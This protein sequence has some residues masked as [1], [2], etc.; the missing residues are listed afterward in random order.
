MTL[1]SPVAPSQSWSPGWILPVILLKAAMV[2]GVGP[3]WWPDSSDY[4]S[5]AKVILRDGL[6]L[7]TVEFYENYN[8]GFAFR[9]LGYPLLLAATKLVFE[10]S[11]GHAVIVFQS[12]LSVALFV[13][14]L[15]LTPFCLKFRGAS[16]LITVLYMLSPMTIFNV[17]ILSDSISAVLVAGSM[18]VILGAIVGAWQFSPR[19]AL[20]VGVAWALSV[21]IRDANLYF[22]FLP[23]VGVLLWAFVRH[24]TVSRGTAM[25][26]FVLAPVLLASEGYKSWNEH[27]TGDRFLSTT[28]SA[29][30]LR[31]VFDLKRHG[32]GDP[33]TGDDAVD[34][35]VRRVKP[36]LS[37][38][39]NLVVL[40][41]LQRYEGVSASNL[42][43]IVRD[44]YI[45]TV[46]MHA[47]PV[48][49][50]GGDSKISNR[51][52]RVYF[53]RP[54]LSIRLLVPVFDRVRSAL[55]PIH[56]GLAAADGRSKQY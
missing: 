44:K 22:V 4:T 41:D 32:L 15:R 47:C 26:V 34:R 54:D 39:E 35:A 33:F 43:N 8:G 46:F 28:G 48:F 30:W 13:L 37:W 5:F 52:K 38:P 3:V 2:I 20:G 29:N 31:P 56:S 11:F 1:E 36:P 27:R 6:W 12:A 14:I 40:P 7:D 9:M 50:A 25:V 16:M 51:K 21:L 19:L 23:V 18:A 17:S 49:Y 53:F 10:D 45:N 55:H 42:N 24:A